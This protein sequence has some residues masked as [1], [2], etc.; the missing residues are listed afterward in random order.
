[1]IFQI[2]FIKNL[3][4]G[5]KAHKHFYLYDH[6]VQYL[7]ILMILRVFTLSAKKNELAKRYF[8]TFS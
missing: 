1:M 4:E 6:R 7:N 5:I 2:F 3:S 8:N